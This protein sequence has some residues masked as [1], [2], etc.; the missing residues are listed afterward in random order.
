MEVGKEMMT[1]LA[2]QELGE[3]SA[4]AVELVIDSTMKDG[5]VKD[6]PIVGTI[7]NLAKLGAGI[8]DLLLAKKLLRFLREFSY[9]KASAR[10]RLVAD[11]AGTEDKREK[12]GEVII[13]LVDRSGSDDKA[14]LIGL[15]FVAAGRGKVPVDALLRLSAIVSQASMS[16]LIGLSIDGVSAIAN[17]RRYALQAQGLLVWAIRNPSKAG[18]NPSVLALAQVIYDT[19]F[20]LEWSVSKDGETILDVCFRG[21]DPQDARNR[22]FWDDVV[23]Y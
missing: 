13:D 11:M 3:L 6:I 12:V 22:E 7:F 17:D 18:P 21:R 20:E 8:R 5:I 14:A 23:S 10:A 9:L 2:S 19:P 1:V 4:D 15:L 16:D